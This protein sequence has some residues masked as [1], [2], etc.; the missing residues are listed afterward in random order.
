MTSRFLFVRKTR[1]LVHRLSSIC[2]GQVN[3]TAASR[4]VLGERRRPSGVVNERHRQTR[5]QRT[6]D[7][8][9]PFVATILTMAALVATT[10]AFEKRMVA[11]DKGATIKAKQMTQPTAHGTEDALKDAVEAIKAGNYPTAAQIL[12]QLESS[13]S[14]PE[15][16]RHWHCP[17]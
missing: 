13:T 9:V 7:V 10:E 16:L 5:P 8:S 17:V 6:D 11:E 4:I 2:P 15:V 3:C 12:T 14:D 1:P